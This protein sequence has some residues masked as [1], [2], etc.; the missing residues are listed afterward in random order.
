MGERLKEPPLPLL[1]AFG[2]A[3]WDCVLADRPSRNAVPYHS[4]TVNWRLFTTPSW[5][6]STP[7]RSDYIFLRPQY[8]TVG[9]RYAQS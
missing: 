2:A 4:N 3:P 1:E 8:L 5:P 6:N 9:V 7:F